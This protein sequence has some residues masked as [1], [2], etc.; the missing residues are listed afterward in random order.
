MGWWSRLFGPHGPEPFQCVNDA[1][2]GPLTWCEDE[3][4]WIG[5]YAGYRIAL[6]YSRSATPDPELVRYAHT[7]MGAGGETFTK[8]L[9]TAQRDHAAEFRRWAAEFSRL[10]V[11][12]VTFA[13]SDQKMGCVVDLVGGEPDR[14]WRVEFEGC[15]CLGFGFD[16]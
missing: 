14:S 5:E 1:M 15:I 16:T 2:F 13:K 8:N 7:F 6:G 11:G 10:T 4:S 12:T 9:S 3:E